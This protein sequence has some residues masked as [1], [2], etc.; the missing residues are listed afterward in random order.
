MRLQGMMHCRLVAL[1]L[2]A[3]V[4]SACGSSPQGN[5]AL[6][7]PLSTVPTVTTNVRTNHPMM[8]LP[9]ATA[10]VGEVV[11]V[12]G[13]GWDDTEPLEVDLLTDAQV[14]SGGY[15]MM[16]ADFVKL[17]QLS[18][19]GGQ[20]AFEFVL[21]DSYETIHGSELRVAIGDKL[22]VYGL[23]RSK[24]GGADMFSGFDPLTVR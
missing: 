20:V 16:H 21:K 10:R 1:S 9:V 11:T 18:V 3:C 14:N 4:L 5:P 12:V 22:H 6:L 23:Q 7:T 8:E 13:T 15:Q 17:G 19:I 24:Q 2:T